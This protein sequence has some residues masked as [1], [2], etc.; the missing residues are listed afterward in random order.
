M[1]SENIGQLI[2]TLTADTKGVYAAKVELMSLNKGIQ[3]TAVKAQDLATRMQTMGRKMMNFYSFG[4]RATMMLTV[5]LVLAGTAAFKLAKDFD[6]AMNKIVGLVGIARDTMESW[7]GEILA[8]APVVGKSP[9]ELAEALYF[10]TS[11]GFKTA[12]ALEITKQAGMAAAAGLGDTATVANVITSAMNAYRDSGLSA[13]HA[14]DILVAAI[15]EGKAEAPGFASAIGQVIP[16]ASELGVSF[17]QVAGAM[18]AMT[19]KGASASNAAVYLK[20]ILNILIDPASETEQLLRKMGSSANRLRGVLEQEGLM[21]ALQEVRVLTEKWGVSI[22]GK[23]FPNIRALI[24]YLSLTGEN[25]EYN[26]MVMDEVK[27]SYGDAAYA[28]E[29]AGKSIQQKWNVALAKG[30][31]AMI[32]LGNAVSSVLLPAFEWLMKVVERIAK[33]F[34]NLNEVVK[35]V[36]IVFGGVMA[37]AGPVYLL[38]AFLLANILPGLIRAFTGLVSIIGKAKQAMVAFK[39]ASVGTV[40]GVVA[41]AITG[42]AIALGKVK[43]KLDDFEKATKNVVQAQGTEIIALDYVFNRLKKTTEGTK[44]RKA[45]IADLN[46]RYGEYLQNLVTEKSSLE[47]IEEAHKAVT[48]VMSSKLAF[49]GYE[50]AIAGQY[51]EV[52]KV[53]SKKMGKFSQVVQKATQG[54]GTTDFLLDIYKTADEVIERESQGI[55]DRASSRFMEASKLWNKYV[56]SLIGGAT[57]AGLSLD[58]FRDAFYE[59]IDIK[60]EVSPMVAL[61]EAEQKKHEWA[62]E[63]LDKLRES[64]IQGV[65]YEDPILQELRLEYPAAM[66]EIEEKI[67]LWG[68][69]YDDVAEK[70]KLNEEWL[71]KI[72]VRQSQIRESKMGA[73]KEAMKALEN[74]A[75]GLQMATWD[76]KYEDWGR[77]IDLLTKKYGFLGDTMDASEARLAYW[78]DQ[79]EEFSKG[80]NAVGGEM[81]WLGLHGSMLQQ[82]LDLLSKKI[83]DARLD[84]IVEGT[85]KA[86]AEYQR[87]YD[88]TGYLEYELEA[89]N[90]AVS[91]HKKFITELGLQLGSTASKTE[92]YRK[93]LE[94]LYQLEYYTF[95]KSAEANIKA[96]KDQEAAMFSLNATSSLYSATMSRISEE[97]EFLSSKNREASERYKELANALM[98]MRLGEEVAS[99]ATEALG[100]LFDVMVD[101]SLTA[102][103]RMKKMSEIIQSAMLSI[104]RDVMMAVAKMLI[105]KALMASIPGLFPASMLMTQGGGLFNLVKFGIPGL[106]LAEGGIVPGGYPNDSYPAMLSSREAVIPLDNLQMS[107]QVLEGEVRFEIEGDRLVGILKKQGI[108]NSLY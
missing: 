26:K 99:R 37:A 31:V 42:I 36:I 62:M 69:A 77:Q 103:E 14:M 28:F 38:F 67:R 101:Q 8:M 55:T 87:M 19:L 50:Q 47:K 23:V 72:A 18:A 94:N 60:A 57:K 104:V 61:M 65:K 35:K 6:A 30:Q 74:Q 70:I 107:P 11:A 39:L 79:W 49:Q 108:K 88:V 66:K 93:E 78:T 73:D 75:L 76:L 90:E 40:F 12:E 106:G 52:A 45:A 48:K 102:E 13:A 32:S 85:R 9:K 44:E 33:W 91:G 56:K 2:V 5:P 64:R 97:M 105:L 82:V 27:N 81:Q 17:D 29:Q 3:Q 80:L 43:N 53:F 89:L 59:V 16:I 1:A 58:A 84:V 10:V 4:Y 54:A 83:Q 20:G 15:R 21:A 63:A 24:G 51:E 25:L 34:D 22:A 92:E 41:L 71:N 86:V 98:Y 7:K 95:K 68:G 100:Q 46:Q 96:L